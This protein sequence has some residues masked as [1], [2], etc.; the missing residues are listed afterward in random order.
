MSDLSYPG[1]YNKT[2]KATPNAPQ[3]VSSSV[4]AI[5][6]FTPEGETNKIINIT[7][8]NEAISKIG[9]FNTKSSVVDA[10]LGYYLNRGKN[11]NLVRVVGSGAEKSD[12]YFSKTKI[13]EN[14][15]VSPLPDGVETDFVFASIDALDKLPMV[16]GSLLV[17]DSALNT[18]T[19]NGDGTLT[20]SIGGAI[21]TIDYLTGEG[22]LHYPSGSEP[23]LATTFSAD[24]SYKTFGFEML[25]EGVAGDEFRV[26]IEGDST[27]NVPSTSSYS[28]YIVKVLRE[29]SVAGVYDTEETFTNVALTDPTDVR[30]IGTVL[31]DSIL[32]SQYIKVIIY[33]N[34]EVPVGLN[35]TQVVAEVLAP[36]PVYDNST[37]TF[38]YIFANSINKLSLDMN[39]YPTAKNENIGTPVVGLTFAGTLGHL[40]DVSQVNSVLL[41][42][43]IAGSNETYIN[44]VT[45]TALVG[46]DGG[47]GTID[48]L[49]NFAITTGGGTFDATVCYANYI[50]DV[51]VN[52]IDDGMGNVSIASGGDN[53]WILDPNA[54]NAIDYDTGTVSITWKYVLSPI[55][56]PYTADLVVPNIAWVQ[57]ADYYAQPLFSQSHIDFTG[58]NDGLAV[59]RSDISGASLLASGKGIYALNQTDD[60]LQVCVPDFESDYL[61][62]QDVLDYCLTRN[63]R[64]FI[65]SVP[66]GLDY[67]GAVNWKKNIVNRNSCEVGACYYPQVKITDTLSGVARNF[68]VG[69][70][71]AGI[72][73]RTFNEV[74]VSQVP[75]GTAYG[76]ISGIIGLEKTLTEGQV[77]FCN[78]ENVNC[79]VNWANTGLVAWGARTLQTNGEMPYINMVQTQM[80][81]RKLL[82]TA[83]YIY[84]FGSNT[85]SFR[86]R[87]Q[88]NLESIL[89]GLFNA[90]YFAGDTAAD[91]FYVICDD[92]NNGSDVAK[93]KVMIE[94]GL[95]LAEPAEFI[96]LTLSHIL[97]QA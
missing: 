42:V 74:N 2:K 84:V 30:F 9:D 62:V 14:I 36:L 23:I 16:A 64:F 38:E 77:G 85:A 97:Q 92:S 47:T 94:V 66:E 33:G 21:G 59:T 83:L 53:I 51:P 11:V 44:S 32:G 93:N 1:I 72:Y 60:I 18:F 7:S 13:G 61:V 73:A 95:A 58:G 55:V 75:A 3:G 86:S 54:T 26:S 65:F 68:P 88:S 31:N 82:N 4:M 41:N 17:T 8:F 25:W 22:T 56:A 76:A 71:M 69:G 89:N 5:V 87:I 20:G 19:D 37:R 96:V 40:P 27:Y 28:K 39:V 90:N 48:A 52:I 91:S 67:D 70:Y 34:N 46:S 78:L 6:G 63:D 49:G 50:W 79:L 35:G 29:S 80:Y 24:Y 57:T 15:T 43:S 12:N 10:L 81:V 45:A